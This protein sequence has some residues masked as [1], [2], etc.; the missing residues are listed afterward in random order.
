M[1]G[2]LSDDIKTQLISLRGFRRLL[3]A[4][5]N[6]PVKQCI[7]CGAVPLFVQ[8]LQRNDCNELQ[9]E[10]AWTLTNIASTDHTRVVVDYGAV[11]F[12]ANL[13][14][15]INPDVREQS[16]WCLGNVAGDCATLRDVVLQ[17]GALMP[18]LANIQQPASLSL[19]HFIIKFM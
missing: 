9:F 10:A 2:M 7:D 11:P 14:A 13:L 6:P 16:A 4:E 1:N 15:S 8:F 12:L 18:I 19:L 5:R 3:S 17:S